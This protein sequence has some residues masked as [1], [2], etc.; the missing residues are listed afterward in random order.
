M[1]RVI[2][3]IVAVAMEDLKVH[4]VNANLPLEKSAIWFKPVIQKG[5]TGKQTAGALYYKY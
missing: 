3:A 1:I 2:F 4:C 5:K